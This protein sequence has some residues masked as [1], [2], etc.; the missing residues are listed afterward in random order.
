MGPTHGDRRTDGRI[1]A[2]LNAPYS[3]GT[4]MPL[5]L[6]RYFCCNFFRR[7]IITAKCKSNAF[8][9]INGTWH[10]VSFSPV[11]QYTLCILCKLKVTQQGQHRAGRGNVCLLLLLLLGWLGS[12]VV[13]VLDSGAEGSGFKSQPR[14]CLRQTV[15]T[16]RASVHQAAKLAATLLRVAKITAGLAENNGSLPL[17]L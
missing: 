11:M 2:S 10:A 6:K 13:S 5:E 7:D 9:L 12:R 14:R 1:A 17:G 16:H 3:G 8:V 4:R 15:R